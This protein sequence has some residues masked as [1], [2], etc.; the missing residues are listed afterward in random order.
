MDSSPAPRRRGA[1]RRSTGRPTPRDPADKTPFGHSVPDGLPGG[2]SPVVRPVITADADARVILDDSRL[3]AVKGWMIRQARYSPAR[4]A[5]GVFALIIA[6]VTALLCL[7]IASASARP[8]PFVDVLFTAVSAVCVTGLTT[9]DTAT[10]WTPF[11]QGV[12]ALGIMI[13]G[14][15]VMTLASILGFAVSRHLGLT[16]RMLAAQETGADSMGQITGLIKAVIAASLTGEAILFAVFLPR[17]LSLGETP[18][19]AVREAAFMSI[20]VFNNAG[21]LIMDGGL[22]PHVHDWWMIVPIVVGTFVGAIGFPVVQ[23]LSA[24]WRTPIKWSLHTKLT[25]SVYLVLVFV[26]AIMLAAT[27]WTNP[28]TLGGLDTPSKILNSLLAG[29]NSRSSGLS[30]LDVGAMHS[31]THFVQV[32]LMMIGGGSASTAGGVKV[33][34]FAVLVLAVVAEARGD[35][36][37]ESFGRRIPPSVVR[38]SVAVSLLGLAMVAVAVVLLL[39]ITD[40]SLDSILFETVSAFATV[41]LSVGITADLPVV[42][43]YVLIGLMFA[44][45]TGTM[46]VAAALALRERSRV[47]RMPE[48]RPIIG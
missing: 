7:P 4:L 14:L 10:S 32:I 35:Q 25:L 39:T 23:D 9:V 8:I 16:Q 18:A 48:E 15:G 22:A 30:A 3:A 28:A 40:Y 13:G 2:P 12:I 37:I 27:E 44:G 33:T 43:K 34:T 24:R 17:F 36:D 47:I 21:F 26:G 46:T 38:L 1:P 5:L 42:G 41:G 31:Q 19:E 45:R 6:V 11:G 20:S 29:V